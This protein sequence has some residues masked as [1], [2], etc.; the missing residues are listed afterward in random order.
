MLLK[1][2]VTEEVHCMDTSQSH[3]LDALLRSIQLILKDQVIYLIIINTQP[4]EEIAE[5]FVF[6]CPR[7]LPS[8]AGRTRRGRCHP[9]SRENSPPG[10]GHRGRAEERDPGQVQ[11][12]EGTGE[13]TSPAR[14]DGENSK[15]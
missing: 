11:A 15:P 7:S 14:S 3:P 6:L 4:L 2:L 13:G 9:E 12:G 5:T 8:L 10:T 1:C